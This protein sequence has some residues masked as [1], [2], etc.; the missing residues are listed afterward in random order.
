[1]DSDGIRFANAIW[2]LQDIAK[3]LMTMRKH[4]MS[5]LK[6]YEAAYT[7]CDDTFTAEIWMK[8]IK[9]METYYECDDERKLV[10]GILD[11]KL[12]S[13]LD[14]N[15]MEEDGALTEDEE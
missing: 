10:L 13:F 8:L 1:V 15:P 3:R 4:L 9:N 12:R 7:N 2:S 11:I 14:S 5:A 6:E